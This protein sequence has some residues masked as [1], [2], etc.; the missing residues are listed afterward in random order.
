MLEHVRSEISRADEHRTHLPISDYAFLSDCHSGALVSRYGSIDWLCWPRFDSPAIFGRLLDPSAGWW[1]IRPSGDADV[2]RRYLPDSLVLETTF[3]TPQGD[4]VLVDALL[5]GPDERGHELGSTAPGVLA[6]TITCVRGAIELELEYA[7]RPEFGLVYPLL[8]AQDGTIAARGGPHQLVLSS[9][10]TAT[11][12]GSTAYARFVMR[13]GARHSFALHYTSSWEPRALPQPPDRVESWIASTVESWQSWSS[14]HRIYEGP[15]EE[16]VRHSGRV[17]QAL[18][19]Q[20]TGALI[21]A[22]TTSLP[23]QIGAARNWDYRFSWVRDACFGLGALWIAACPDEAGT[24]FEFL[25]E[26]ALTQVRRD[27]DLQIMFG[28]GGEHDLSERELPYLSGWRSS[29]PVRIGNGAW[30]QRQLDVYGELVQAAY[31]MRSKLD[32]GPI[33]REFLI[34]VVETA[35][36]RWQGPDRGIWEIRGEPRHF[37]HSK[38][39]CWVALDRGIELADLLDAA[40]YVERWQIA[41]DEIRRTI[42]ERGWNAQAGTFVQAFDSDLLDAALLLI[43]ILGFL[44]ADDPRVVSTIE[45]IERRLTDPHG[46]VLRYQR[47]DG[48]HEGSFLMCT[49]WLAQAQAMAGRL[50]AA[51]ATFALAAAYIN[52]VGLMS[53]EVDT[54]SHELLGNFPQAF[55]HIGLINAAWA[56]AE[57]ERVATVPSH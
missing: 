45:T 15:W 13:E 14:L 17:L 23:E 31:T 36:R 27:G 6:R 51:R 30:N 9:Q 35:R 41:R 29:S 21:A 40:D 18:T 24:F 25:A 48:V 28:V 56:I 10:V 39:M 4:A 57:A 8:S 49:F 19:F 7:P 43:P 44:P 37:V 33:A 52:D 50:D 22:A 32:L 46:L 5:L 16:L 12:N 55:S 47:T 38:L 20:P 26:T 34:D 42:L 2:S 3:R 53:E 1:S 11:I 54:A